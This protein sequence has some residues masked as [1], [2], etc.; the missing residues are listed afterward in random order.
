MPWTKTELKR[1]YPCNPELIK[2][3][4]E[5]K[6]WSQK[7]LAKESG[8]CERLICKA[9]SGGS[10]A[11][12]TI[13]V[14]AQTLSCKEMRVFPEDLISDPVALSRNF[15]KAAHTLQRDMVKGIRHFTHPHGTFRFV[16][17]GKG[18][19]SGDYQGIGQLDNAVEEFFKAQTFVPG[20]DFE[21]RYSYYADGNAVIAWGISTIRVT[22]TDE[23]IDLNVT[24]RL[25][26][27]KGKLISIEDRSEVASDGNDNPPDGGT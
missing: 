13:E 10:I 11:S 7:R 18:N 23:V 19:Y 1:S 26:Y 3:L 17:C 24:L 21:N 2:Y 22:E 8:Y 5:R 20:Q 25:E 9:E 14:L 15:I 16:Q 27:E 12:A 6:K 4:R